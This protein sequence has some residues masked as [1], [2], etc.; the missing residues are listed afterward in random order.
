MPD[1]LAD[2]MAIVSHLT[3]RAIGTKADQI[4]LQADDSRDTILI[5]VVSLIEILYLSEKKRININPREVIKHV[6]DS[7]NYGLLSLNE[8]IV[9]V[10]STID[11][12]RE[13]HD[14]LIAATAKHYNIPILTNDPVLERSK[15]ITT[16]W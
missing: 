12:I 11:D 6:N 15:H 8:D 5:S 14:R 10:A 4:F 1:Y 9:L 2:T 3:D 16:L 13:L 7:S